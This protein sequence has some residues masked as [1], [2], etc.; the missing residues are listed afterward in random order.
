MV[1]TSAIAKAADADPSADSADSPA[2]IWAGDQGAILISSLLK[3]VVVVGIVGVVLFDAISM[4]TTQV[5]LD[6]AVQEAAQVGHDS[7]ATSHSAVTAEQ[8]VDLYATQHGD[9]VP[10]NGIIIT[11]DG[12]VTVTLAAKAH[13]IAAHYLSALTGHI[14]VR[15][16]A[17]ATNATY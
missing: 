17:T 10:A 1:T 3:F 16:T 8:Q 7:Y 9:S 5:Q 6:S 13:T 12:T 4:T 2:R 11:A 14:N 15:A